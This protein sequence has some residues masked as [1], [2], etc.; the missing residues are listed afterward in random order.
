MFEVFVVKGVNLLFLRFCWYKRLIIFLI[1]EEEFDEEMYFNNFVIVFLIFVFF[2]L[3][4]IFDKL[5]FLV[6]FLNGKFF[7]LIGFFFGFV[8]VLGNLNFFFLLML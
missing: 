8:W 3:F 6:I 7:C 1:F 5:N 4:K 2:R